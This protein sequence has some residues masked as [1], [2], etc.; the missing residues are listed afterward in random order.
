MPHLSLCGKFLS[1]PITQTSCVILSAASL[2]T[3]CNTRPPSKVLYWS[4]ATSPSLML[5]LF[6]VL[7]LL[8]VLM[9]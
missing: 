7:D 2:T 8:L 4:L 6:L 1:K 9:L 3:F 5:L